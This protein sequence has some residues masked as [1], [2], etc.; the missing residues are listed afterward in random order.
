LA[1]V[2][3]FESMLMVFL[4][5]LQQRRLKDAHFAKLLKWKP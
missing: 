5:W 2:A 1:L 4:S 3:V